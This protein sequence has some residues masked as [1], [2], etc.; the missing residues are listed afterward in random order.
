M[1]GNFSEYDKC[2][3]CREQGDT[4]YYR[5]LKPIS[6]ETSKSYPLVIHLH[7]VHERGLDNESQLKNGGTL[8]LNPQYRIQFP[9]FVMFPQCPPQQRWGTTGWNEQVYNQEVAPVMQLI[10]ETISDLKKN[11]P[12]DSQRLYIMGLSMG[13]FGTFDVLMR[14]PELFAAAIVICGGG[15]EQKAE[16]FKHIPIWLLHGAQDD[17]VK[18]ESSRRMFKTLTEIG[19]NVRYTEYADVKHD[20]W[21]NAY[22]EPDLL[23]WLFAQKKKETYR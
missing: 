9:A 3:Y 5:L 20:S 8:F 17:V 16:R 18:V 21:N 12:I 10:L 22:K 14:R 7:G 2:T 11:Y 1:T 15:I 13:G 6:I 4:L 19:G 23:A